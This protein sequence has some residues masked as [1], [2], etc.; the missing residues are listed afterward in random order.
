MIVPVVVILPTRLSPPYHM[1][2][3]GPTVIAVGYVARSRELTQLSFGRQ[4]VDRSARDVPQIPI[5]PLV[6]ASPPGNW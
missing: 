1:S 4:P 6:I 2:P 5:R 3:S